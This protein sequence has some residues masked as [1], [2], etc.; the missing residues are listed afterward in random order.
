MSIIYRIN[1]QLKLHG[2]PEIPFGTGNAIEIECL[3]QCII[4]DIRQLIGN[5][6]ELEH[7]KNGLKT[8]FKKIAKGRNYDKD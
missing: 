3:Y 5:S 8:W 1:Q 4:E 6:D 2:R 7:P